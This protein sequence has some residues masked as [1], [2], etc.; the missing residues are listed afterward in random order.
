M[1]VSG[2]IEKRIGIPD[3]VD[4]A[5][6]EDKVTISSRGSIVER[7]FFHPLVSIDK[8]GD[9]I[10]VS[11]EFP[12]KKEA[13]LVG[14]FASHIKN[15]MLGTAKGFECEMRIVY[16][17][18][19]MKV[20]VNEERSIVLIENFLG[21]RHPRTARI[22]GET[23]VTVKGDTVKLKGNSKEDVG[24][25]AANIEQATK[26][27]GYDPR[28]FQDGVYIIQKPRVQENE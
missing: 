17:H 11:C 24:Q 20:S 7:R 10:V 5:V 26:I 23:E 25:S 4:A 18:F 9:E 27:K 6:E 15:M 14:T 1:P 21:E 8:D 16:A 13:A 28:V 2:R 3:G 22:M 12:K 19:P